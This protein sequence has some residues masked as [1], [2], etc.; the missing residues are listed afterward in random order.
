MKK[1]F[2]PTIMFIGLAVSG[3]AQEK[4]NKEKQGDKYYFVYSF[5][6][7]IDCYTHVKNLS[8]DGQRKLAKS[9][10]DENK[11][12]LA[13]IAY[14]KLLI[15][16]GGNLPEDYYDYAMILKD[17]GKYQESNKYMDKFSKLKPT[18]LRAKDYLANK[19]ELP[20]LLKDDS[21]YA[22]MHL[23]INNDAQDF[24]PVYYK[25]KIVFTSS[26]ETPKLIQRTSNRNGKPDLNLFIADVENGQMKNPVVFSEKFVDKLNTG[27]ASFSNDSAYIAYTQN[28][29]Q[30]TKQDR[31]VS[32]EIYFRR[33]KDGKWSEPEAFFLNSKDYSVGHPSLTADGNTMYFTS[34]MPGGYGGTDIYKIKKD[35]K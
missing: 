18:D 8:V 13:E 17:N 20:D 19:A 10:Q 23:D 5:T 7:A 6:K 21:K 30:L 22:I 25:N 16:A 14:S 9:Y 2:I 24:G 27:T 1:L 34:D 4:S 32:L 31:V 26:R 29:E 3:F 33:Y 35:E 28:N 11:D 12:T 15:T